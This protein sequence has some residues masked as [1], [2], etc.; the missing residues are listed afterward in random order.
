MLEMRKEASVF[1]VPQD[2]IR[3]RPTH[4]TAP[5]CSGSQSHDVMLTHFFATDNDW[6]TQECLP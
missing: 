5:V 4:S 6:C 3:E 1:K 2:Q